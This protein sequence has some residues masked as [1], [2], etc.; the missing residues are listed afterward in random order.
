MLLRVVF[1]DRPSKCSQSNGAGLL[2]LTRK[3]VRRGPDWDGRG[4]DVPVEYGD[5][6][7]VRLD[8]V[9]EITGDVG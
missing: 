5:E 6:P 1:T 7:E 3:G 4:V 9:G 2:G 8:V